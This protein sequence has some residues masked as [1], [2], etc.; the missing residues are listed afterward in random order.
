M[1]ESLAILGIAHAARMTFMPILEE[2][3]K[4]VAKDAAKNYV[5]NAFESVFSVI[6][7]TPL[8]KATGQALQQLLEL[9]DNELIGGGLDED[10]RRALLPYVRLF[11]RHE[12]VKG[13]L[14]SLFLNPDFKLDPA[15]LTQA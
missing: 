2:L 14:E 11:I 3:A 7:K 13:S 5:T 10:K 15:D 12:N 4:E 9:I 1:I 6:Y 8:N